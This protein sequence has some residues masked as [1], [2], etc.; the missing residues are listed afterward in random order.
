[1][2]TK[3]FAALLLT[4]AIAIPASAQE[5]NLGTLQNMQRTASAF[6]MIEQGGATAASLNE[7]VPFVNVP[8]GFEASLYAVVPDARSM[9]VA[10]QGTVVF[11]GT[12]KD[13]V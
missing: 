13:K 1:M 6:T 12:R 10:P 5:D 11:V 4:T 9:A 2:N 8:D 7:I 3:S